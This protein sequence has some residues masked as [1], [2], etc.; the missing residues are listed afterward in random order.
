[1]RSLV[2]LLVVALLIVL[3]LS[4]SC[5]AQWERTAEQIP[6]L[7]S[8]P[9]MTSALQAQIDDNGGTL[10]L[11]A[12]NYRIKASGQKRCTTIQARSASE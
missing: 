4:S 8:L 1:M 2:A 10:L 12:K 3:G 11:T 5:H 7:K 6:N 9:D